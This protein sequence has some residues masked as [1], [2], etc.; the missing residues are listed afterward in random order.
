[1]NIIVLILV[2]AVALKAMLGIHWPW[3]KCE[4][5]GKKWKE[6]TIHYFK[7]H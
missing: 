4:C 1:M 5:C 6:H 3:E 2:C 7:D